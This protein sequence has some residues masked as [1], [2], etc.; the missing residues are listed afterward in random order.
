MTANVADPIAAADR[1]S[2]SD[3][4]AAGSCPLTLADLHLIPVRYAYA[5]EDPGL[6]QLDPRFATD[7]RPM[8]IRTV[9]DGY[10]YLFHS[11]APDILQEFVVTEGGAVEKRL[12]EGDDA[13]QDQREGIPAE[14]AI[15]VP[16]KGQIEVLFSE[17]QLTAKKCSMLI[18]WQ[19]YR[20]QV[21]RTVNLNGYCPESGHAHLLPKETLET[22]LVH[23][24]S[25]EAEGELK[26]WYWAAESDEAEQEPFAH[27]LTKYEKDHAYLVVDDLIGQISDLLDAWREVDTRLNDWLAEEDVRYYPAKFIHGLMKLDDETV[28]SF[29]D[30]VLTQVDDPDEIEALERIG[31]ASAAQRQEV[32]D[33]AKEYVSYGPGTQF[34]ASETVKAWQVQSKKV[35]ELA[36]QL[37]TSTETL[38]RVLE[39][40]HDNQ[41][42]AEHGSL[43]GERGIRHLVKVDDMNRYLEKAEA[44]LEAFHSEK[45]KIAS[46]LQALVPS[47]HLVGHVYDRQEETAYL[48]FLGLDNAQFNV[49]NEYAEDAGDFSFLIDYYFG[50]EVGHQHLVSF[51]ID[52]EAY[53]RPIAKLLDALKKILD[54]QDNAVAYDDWQ[55]TL[56]ENPQLRFATL[57]PA[58]SAELSQRLA[59]KQPAAKQALFKLVEKTSDA[60]LQDRLRNVFKSMNAGLRS[61]LL[62][63]QL[64]YKLDLAIADEGTL[65]KADDLIRE[66]ETHASQYREYKDLENRLDEQRRDS[67]RA[68]RKDQKNI[69]DAEI[70]R[71]R[72]ARRAEGKKVKQARKALED[73]PPSEG[74]KYNGIL[75]IGNLKGTAEARAVMAELDELEKLRA[76]SGMK[77]VFDHARGLVNGD[78]AGDITKRIGGLGVVSFMGLV[79]FV[80]LAES[81]KKWWNDD[82]DGS[83]LDV[84][85]SGSGALGATASVVTIVGSAR[86]NYYYQHVSKAESV[87]T[88]LARANVWGGTI[89]A[90]GGFLAAG[91]DGIK[92]LISTF[93]ANQRTGQR[94]GSALALSGDGMMVYGSGRLGWMGSSGINQIIRKE[95]KNVTWRS[96]HKGML[97][98]GGGVF[99]GMNAWLWVGTI[100]VLVGEYIHNRFTRSELQAWCEKSQWGNE[101]KGWEADEQRYELAKLTYSPELSVMAEREALNQQFRYCAIEL[102]LPGISKLSSD[103]AE[104]VIL[105]KRGTEWQTATGEWSEAFSLLRNDEEGVRL[106]ASLLFDELELVN[107]LYLAVRFKPD[108][109][110]DWLPGS[111]KAFH[112]RLTLHEHGNVPHVPANSEKAWQPLKV[113]EEAEESI[114]PLLVGYKTVL[115]EES[116]A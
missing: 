85:S 2:M 105:E 88:R 33:L 49:L 29:V 41:E 63:S 115:P 80:G 11:S 26:P 70:R 44:T 64:L 69:Y 36:A 38:D 32:A 4:T 24:E 109:V 20:S 56:A 18:G 37:A 22:A 72:A 78:N 103:N 68:L 62:D 97:G 55:N 7:F 61:H 3:S 5:E 48:D 104:W 94:V 51:D 30:A 25:G 114:I 57:T 90:W 89:A 73:L 21:M 52:P 12:W 81:F 60:R 75:K 95:A 34:G 66:L 8:G 99:R 45:E 1:K 67:N 111:G 110:S 116:E 83:V 112:S 106:R 50:N 42:K 98:L 16:R 76:R 93:D 15:V 86:L 71:L 13:T 92:R 39:A 35:K 79:S 58:L 91:A 14:K 108:G 100:L 17:T 47:Y 31:H 82:E 27:R 59:Q 6:R 101:S 87:L 84:I 9:R 23:P 28:A 96:V 46:S 102:G 54:A 113:A 40:L 74:N 43:T 10:L 77:A 19:D 53:A 107:A 65:G